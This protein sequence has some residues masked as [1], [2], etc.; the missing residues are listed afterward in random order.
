MPPYQ[1]EPFARREFP[2]KR[3]WEPVIRRI[4]LFK[5]WFKFLK[6]QPVFFEKFDRFLDRSL[7]CRLN[8]FRGFQFD[9]SDLDRLSTKSS[10][11]DIIPLASLFSA[12]PCEAI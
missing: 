10:D 12:S 1:G 5:R 3:M 11:V 4:E 2:K 8:N 6:M 7:P 9:L